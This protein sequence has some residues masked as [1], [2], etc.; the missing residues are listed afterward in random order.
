MKE[1]EDHQP[2]EIVQNKEFVKEYKRYIGT[3]RL[4]KGLKLFSGLVI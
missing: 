3:M 2:I 4:K 1:I